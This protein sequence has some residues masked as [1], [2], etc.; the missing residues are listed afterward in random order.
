MA[1]V[2]NFS[3]EPLTNFVVEKNVKIPKRGT[4]SFRYPFGTMQVSDSFFVGA[5]GTV[6]QRVR[7][8]SGA[9]GRRTNKKFSVLKNYEGEYRCWRIK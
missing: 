5:D 2:V 7:S 1:K 6:A 3:P 8:A 4:R 9:Y